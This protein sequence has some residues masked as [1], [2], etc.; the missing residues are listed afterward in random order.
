MLGSCVCWL[1]VDY[2]FIFDN[3][4]A[5]TCVFMLLFYL[6]IAATQLK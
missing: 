2:E 5:V 6:L 3:V 1:I 4:H